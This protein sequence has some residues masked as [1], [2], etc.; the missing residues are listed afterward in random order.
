VKSLKAVGLK[1]SDLAKPWQVCF[2]E[3]LAGYQAGSFP[4]GAAVFDSNGSLLARGRNHIFDNHAAPGQ[5]SLNQLAHAELNT[6]LQIDRRSHD[7]HASILYTSLEP[8]PLCMGAIYMSG[9]RKIFYGARDSFAGST[10]LLGTTPYMTRKNVQAVGP[11]EPVLETI[12]LGLQVLSEIRRKNASGWLLF[13]TVVGSWK[14]TCPAA[15][16]LGQ[17]LYDRHYLDQWI[18]QGCVP[19]H[20]FEMLALEAEKS[21]TSG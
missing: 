1:W 16:A 11:A 17:T 3:A 8:C 15:V 13:E 20:T 14:G 12:F 6:L 10:D 2:E 5:V 7:L 9:I 4:I 19:G 18:D 21:L